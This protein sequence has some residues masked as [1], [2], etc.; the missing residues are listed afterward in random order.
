[1]TVIQLGG[2]HGNLIRRSDREAEKDR[3]DDRGAKVGHKC[4][5][6]T[7]RL[8]VPI[9]TLAAPLAMAP[10]DRVGDRDTDAERWRPRHRC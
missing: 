2:E 5:R 4:L 8:A 9:V 6:R 1:M 10:E 7:L 3:P